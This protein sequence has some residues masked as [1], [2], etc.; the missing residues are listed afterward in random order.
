MQTIVDFLSSIG[1]M[2]M[3]AFD[4]LISTIHDL[5]YVAK[6]L[7]SFVI[8]IPLYFAWLPSESVAVLV[9]LFGVVV[10]YKLLG[11]EG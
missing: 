8:N 5:A 1:D 10:I 11:R 9:V 2:A 7:G 3:S 4:W 6:L